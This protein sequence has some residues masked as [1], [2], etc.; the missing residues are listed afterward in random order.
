MFEPGPGSQLHDL[1]P[2]LFPPSGLFWTIEVPVDNVTVDLA[3]GKATLRGTNVPILDYGDIPNALS[4]ARPPVYGT[5]TFRVEWSGAPAR[6]PI[7]KED[8]VYGRYVGEF[9]RNTAKVEWSARVGDF[10]FQSSPLATSSSQFALLGQERNG[11][12]FS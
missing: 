9:M 8:P 7:R 10:E 12:F 11:V 5:V 1:N 6:I 4:G 2:T 3:S